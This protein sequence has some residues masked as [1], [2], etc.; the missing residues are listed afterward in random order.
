[1]TVIVH[2]QFTFKKVGL[3]DER[4]NNGFTKTA[5]RDDYHVKPVFNIY[6]EV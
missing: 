1:M 6:K 3:K 2:S 5:N 4:E